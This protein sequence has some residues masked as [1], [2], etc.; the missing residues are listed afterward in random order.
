MQNDTCD[1]WAE[2]DDHTTCRVGP[3]LITV[4]SRHKIVASIAV[5][6]RRFDTAIDG[7]SIYT[8]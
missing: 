4:R 2:F 1:I 8:R 7:G 6:K 5:S 3:S